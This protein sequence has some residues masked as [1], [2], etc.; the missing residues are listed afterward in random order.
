MGE[1]IVEGEGVNWDDWMII[2]EEEK[3]INQEKH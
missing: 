2:V 1:V 3:L